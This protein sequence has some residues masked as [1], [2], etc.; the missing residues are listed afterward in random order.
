[1]GIDD[2]QPDEDE[3]IMFDNSLERIF[4]LKNKD[5]EDPLIQSHTLEAFYESFDKKTRASVDIIVTCIC[6]YS[7]DTIINNSQEISRDDYTT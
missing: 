3:Q 4:S 2:R 5:L 1:M 7:L 6:G